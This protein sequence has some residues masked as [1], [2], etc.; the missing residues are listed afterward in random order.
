M[1]QR[2]EQADGAAYQACSNGAPAFI[3]GA[4][5][6][7][8]GSPVEGLVWAGRRTKRPQQLNMRMNLIPA[9][10]V[11]SNPDQMCYAN[12][13]ILALQWMG[14]VSGITAGAAYGGALASSFAS[15][16]SSGP[17]LLLRMA[18]WRPFFMHWRQTGQQQDCAEFIH[19]LLEFAKPAA[20]SG[21]W[22]GR[23]LLSE[24]GH[25][26]LHIQDQGQ[27]F[28]PVAMELHAGS[29]QHVIDRWEDQL[30]AQALQVPCRLWILQL[31]QFAQIPG[32]AGKDFQRITLRPGEVVN[33]PVFQHGMQ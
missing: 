12:V 9:S 26:R 19:R 6:E 31:L 22:Q 17:N 16:S 10:I 20:Y 21:L 4:G 25:A 13:G 28:C 11:L 33:M 3:Q 32:G 29:L 23:M 2:L 8:S 15:L 7:I 27:T 5:R 24:N 1:C 14:T 30:S 18:A